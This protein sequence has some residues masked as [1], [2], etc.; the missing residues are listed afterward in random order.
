[1]NI[2]KLK[3]CFFSIN[4]YPLF[5]PDCKDIFGG[6]EIQLYQLAKKISEH[7]DFSVSFFV[8]D[9]GQKPVERYGKIVVL[10]AYP[11]DNR[12]KNFF[13]KIYHGIFKKL[14]FFFK[15]TSLNPDVCVHRAAGIETGI[16]CFFAKIFRR[17][18]IYM[19]ASLKDVDGG[20]AETYRIRGKI[21]EYGLKNTD[22]VLVQSKD[23]QKILKEKYGKHSEI[24]K[25][26]FPVPESREDGKRE[27]ILWVGSSQKLKQ[28]E[29][30]LE[31]AKQ[32]PDE[33]FLMVMPK[34][35]LILWEKIH[36]EAEKVENLEFIERVPFENI[37]AYFRQTK[38]FVNTSTFE[39]FPNTFVQAAMFGT[40]IVSLNVNPDNFINEYGCGYCADGDM[41]KT[42]EQIKK[43]L[44]NQEDWK[45]KSGNARRYAEENHDIEKNV[46]KL[47][48]IIRSCLA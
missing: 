48:E 8:A 25:N 1:M 22:L 23:Q 20:Y 33:K 31:L 13:R 24:L 30:F 42:K 12:K 4:A 47:K 41:D 26:S 6:A 5:N 27:F 43:L 46:E 2:T 45:V 34:N 28:P 7:D 17:K 44:E 29:K 16:I 19:V 3:I 11:I 35:D 32:F 38:L 40:P 37:D 18:F 21:Y 10:K 39:G 36:R 14:V 15:L 9:V